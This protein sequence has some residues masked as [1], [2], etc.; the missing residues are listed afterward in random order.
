MAQRI[1]GLNV[2]CLIKFI[3]E[4][5]EIE[6]VDVGVVTRYTVKV[7][8]GFTSVLLRTCTLQT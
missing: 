8:L 5:L 4:I 2:E 7:I 3:T 6:F 1:D